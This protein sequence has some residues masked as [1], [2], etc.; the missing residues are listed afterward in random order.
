MTNQWWDRLLGILNYP[1][2]PLG[3]VKL[4][5]AVVLQ[6]SLLLFFLFY[7]STRIRQWFVYNLLSRTALNVGTRQTIGAIFY[8]LM[9]LIG[10]M[11]V[12][13]TA[14][15][16]LTALSVAA[17]GLGIGIG[18]GLQSIANNFVSGFV[19]LLERPIKVGDRI[20]VAGTEGQVVEI[21]ARATTVLTNDNIAILI[22]NS[23]FI[24]EEVINWSYSDT[25]VRFRVPVMVG[26]DSDVR[27]V[28][29]LLLSVGERNEDVLREPA[30][31]VRFVE[32]GD[33]GL[34]FELRVWSSSL[35]QRKGK[36]VSDLNFAILDSFRA[37]NIT[38]PY[39]QRVVHLKSA[40]KEDAEA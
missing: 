13:Q 35:V 22:P 14:G 32:F 20:E 39:P 30:P 6:L 18:F 28:E 38:M 9:L 26:Y 15:I 29:R 2:L 25:K 23:R 21:H 7:A 16:D 24:T 5:L 40:G 19:V 36:L 4:S 27:Q 10:S 8:Y 37:H 12:L 34:R 1:I 31:V 3:S 17:G 11:V 33:S